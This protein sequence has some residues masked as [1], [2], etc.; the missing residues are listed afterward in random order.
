[1]TFAPNPLKRRG[2]A[3]RFLV[4]LAVIFVGVGWFWNSRQPRYQG[5]SVQAW[6][7]DALATQHRDFHRSKSQ[8]AFDAMGDAAIP[9][10]RKQLEARPSVVDRAYAKVHALLPLRLRD[11][12]REPLTYENHYRPRE[13][14]AS[15]IIG[16]ILLPRQIH[17]RI[18]E[19]AQIRT[20]A[21]M[22]PYTNTIVGTAVGYS[23]VPIA[24]GEFLMGSPPSE[25][26]RSDDEGLQVRVRLD[27]FWI[28]QFE[29]TWNQFGLFLDRDFRRQP[30]HGHAKHIFSGATADA[31]TRPSTP[32]ID[33]SMGMGT[34]GYPAI[35]MTQHAANKF[36]EWLSALTGHFYRLP[37]EAEWEYACRAGTTT[38]YSFEGETVE[39]RDYAWFEANSDGRY[40]KVGR[41][42]PNP[43]GLYDMHGNVAE[44]TLD[45]Y[46]PRSYLLNS[47]RLVVNPWNRATRPYPHVV[48]GGA[49]NGPPERLRSAARS[50][51]D[52]SWKQDDPDLPKSV[53]YHT[54]ADHVGFRI[55]RPLKIPIAQEMKQYWNSGV[56]FD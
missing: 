39:L 9:F 42:K 25:L 48:R 31:I 55:V 27:P 56:E 54:R 35:N 29:V 34:N 3:L 15:G 33:F 2:N 11:F 51:S 13:Q 12:L 32:Y 50:F 24:A 36:C 20:E 52:R 14:V 1:M 26:G 7:E 23:M 37:T 22:K 6:F 16:Q 8:E 10:L 41:K 40:Q 47:D 17:R 21:E 18:L 49:W 19:R 38:A 43:W 53:W 5:R 45:Q 4:S 28:G 46:D 44:W 30:P